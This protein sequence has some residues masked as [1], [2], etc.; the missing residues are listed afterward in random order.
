MRNSLGRQVV[1]L[2]FLGGLPMMADEPFRFRGGSELPLILLDTS[3]K[4]IP[5]EPKI[6]AMLSIIDNG[7]DKLNTLSDAKAT[8]ASAPMKLKSGIRRLSGPTPP[9]STSRG[10]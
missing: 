9:S 10:A 6:E 8:V 7:H 3:A 4:P 2:L 1:L 5:N